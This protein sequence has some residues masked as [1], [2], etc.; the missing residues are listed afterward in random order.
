EAR[1]G[2][3]HPKLATAL[4]WRGVAKLQEAAGVA[5]AELLFRRAI[6][7]DESAHGGEGEADASRLSNLGWVLETRG[8]FAEAESLL[9]RAVEAAVEGSGPSHY[10]TGRALSY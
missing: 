3:R 2:P 6:G 5:S 1:F 10:S 7:I 4:S 8:R 9:T